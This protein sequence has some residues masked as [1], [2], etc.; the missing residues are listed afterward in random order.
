MCKLLV[1]AL[2]LCSTAFAQHEGHCGPNIGWVPLEILQRPMTLREGVGKISDPVATSSP[3][4]QAFYDQGMAYIHNYVWIEAARS[5]HHALR[6][7]PKLAMAHLGLAR[8]YLNMD[9]LPQAN[10][11]LK[12]AQ[13]LAVGA[14]ARE[15]KRIAAMAKHLESLA[16]PSDKEKFQAYRDSLDQA[17]AQ[18]PEDAELWIIR[19]NASEAS[20]HGR[21]QRGAAQSIAYY[22]AALN[23]VPGHWGANHYLIHSYEMIGKIDQALVHGQ[24]YA[25]AAYN[26]P[27]A[28]HMFGH[29]LR[30]NG[31]TDDAIARFLRAKE[32]EEAYYRAEKIDAGYDWHRNHNLN[33][34]A[35][36][37]QYQGRMKEAEQLLL[38]SA[39]LPVHYSYQELNKKDYFEFLLHRGR[40]AEALKHAQA[41]AKHGRFPVGR[42]AGHALAGQALLALHRAEEAKRELEAAKAEISG[43]QYFQ[44]YIDAL[45][46]E[47]MLR[48]K[49]SKAD[50]LLKSVVAR[51]RAVPGPDAWMQAIYRIELLAR[52]A[53][54]SNN[55]AL[56]EFMANEMLDHD[57]HY[58]GTHYALALVA[59]HKGNKQGANEHFAQA[60]AAWKKADPGL[61]E[62]ADIKQRGI[63]AQ[64]FIPELPGGGVI[65]DSFNDPAAY[66]QAPFDPRM[67]MS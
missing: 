46:G 3:Q 41:L 37:Y 30:R 47:L 51:V 15:Q 16:D 62:A 18:F 36:S 55:W 14:S 56:A 43:D 23:R 7:D 20:P 39:S 9:A 38:D 25:D 65:A 64:E 57:Q 12:M 60:A 49:D 52:A 29:D 32:L 27:H 53:R 4:A 48:A 40:Y 26:I 59:E 58:A 6:L 22:E 2:L 1:A 35:T 45:E 33:L 31:K 11:E 67:M 24:I 50:E 19:G 66:T 5:F 42:A 63:V 44:P 28:H 54:E 61:A 13:A 34:L 10:D 17:L 8:T 21:G